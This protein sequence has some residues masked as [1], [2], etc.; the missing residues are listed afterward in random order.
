MRTGADRAQVEALR[1]RLAEQLSALVAG[2]SPLLAEDHAESAATT[3]LPFD[4][5]KVKPVAE[6][7]LKQLSEFDAAV[8]DEFEAERALFASLFSA[9]DLEQFEQHLENYAFGDAQALLEAAAKARGL[10]VHP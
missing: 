8:S 7:M 1:Q 3:V 4:P 2:L 6:K 10:E 9:A 5:L